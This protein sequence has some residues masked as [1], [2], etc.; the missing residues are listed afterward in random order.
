MAM[1]R[2]QAIV[3]GRVQGVLFR[4][5]T[6]KE[7]GRFGLSGWVRNR[8][9]GTVE[10]EF[11]GDAEEVALMVNWLRQGSPLSQVTGVDTASAK[12]NPEESGFMVR[13]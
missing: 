9:D 11:Q 13:Y 1:V 7:A 8:E 10:T 3:R 4:D 5:Y 2:I 12:V 6:V